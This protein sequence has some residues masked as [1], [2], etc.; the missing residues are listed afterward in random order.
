MRNLMD[1]FGKNSLSEFPQSIIKDFEIQNKE[2]DKKFSKII[3]KL[4][5][6]KVSERKKALLEIVQENNN[7]IL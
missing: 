4:K 1:I 2:I 6:K 3:G 7:T 5:E